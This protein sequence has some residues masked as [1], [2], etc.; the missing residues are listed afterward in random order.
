MIGGKFVAPADGKKED[1]LDLATGEVIAKASLSGKR[2][3]DAAVKAAKDAFDGWATTTPGE[4]SLALLR[5]ADA[6]EERAEEI[7]DPQYGRAP[8]SAFLE[9]EIPFMADN[10]RYFAGVG[11]NPRVGPPAST[12][13]GTPVFIRREPVGSVGQITPWNYPLMMAI[14]KIGLALATGNT[15]VLSRPRRLR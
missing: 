5:I 8:R 2:D 10:L 6:I 1:V 11:S 14:W 13:R 7:A 12:P 4:R 3:V 9:D 15:V